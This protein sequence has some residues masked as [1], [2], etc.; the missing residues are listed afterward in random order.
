MLEIHLNTQNFVLEKNM[1]S[2]FLILPVTFLYYLNLTDVYLWAHL[3]YSTRVQAVKESTV[4]NHCN[5]K[6]FLKSPCL[7]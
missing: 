1:L 6:Y 2:P 5:V 7:C 4:T 3:F